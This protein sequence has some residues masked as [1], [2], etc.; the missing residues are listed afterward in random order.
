MSNRGVLATFIAV[1]IAMISS[2]APVGAEVLRVGLGELDYPPYYFFE[3]GAY[4][5]AA[6]EIAQE[7]AQALG[8]TLVFRRFPWKRV[9]ASLRA[10]RIDMVILY[11]KTP[12]RE[13]DAVFTDI[14]H[15]NEAS[16]LFVTSGSNIAY[17][18]SLSSL[19]SYRFGNVRGYSHGAEYDNARGLYKHLVTDERLLIKI[20]LGGRIDIGVGNKAA[21][22]MYAERDRV[23]NQIT[24]LHPP[25]DEGRDYI[26]FSRARAD[27]EVLAKAYSQQIRGLIATPRYQEILER[28]GVDPLE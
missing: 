19:G 18:G 20:L 22:L 8:H 21:V 15:L 9:Q 25:I 2:T 10:G 5:G 28:Y 27:A 24:F 14:S 16:Y 7:V 17:N 3:D 4:Q 13:R 23:R 11:F 1:W 26:A 6:I 12:E